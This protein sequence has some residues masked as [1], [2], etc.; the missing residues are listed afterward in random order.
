MDSRKNDLSQYPTSTP[1]IELPQCSQIPNL[2]SQFLYSEPPES[3]LLPMVL[4][5]P[6]PP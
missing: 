5:Q 2:C 3:L 4:P 6:D 1:T